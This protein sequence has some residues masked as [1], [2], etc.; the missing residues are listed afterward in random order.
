VNITED[1]QCAH[2]PTF[3]VVTFQKERGRVE[4]CAIQETVHACAQLYAYILVHS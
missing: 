4:F 3:A 2:P 1:I